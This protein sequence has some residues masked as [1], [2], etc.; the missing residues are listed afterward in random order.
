MKPS[1]LACHH[2]YPSR[3]IAQRVSLHGR[4]AGQSLGKEILARLLLS[5]TFILLPIAESWAQMRHYSTG[6]T[7]S[8]R[9]FCD[10]IPLEIENDQLYISVMMGDTPCRLNLDTGSGQGIVYEGTPMSQSEELG[11]V[12]SRDANGQQDT[13]R[14]VGLPPFRL[15]HSMISGYVASVLP[16]PKVPAPYDGIIGFDLFNKGLS[17]KIDTRQRILILTDQQQVFDHEE[18]FG[19]KYKLKWFVPYIYVSPFMRHTDEAL[20]D[21]GSRALYTM[22]KQSFDRHAYKS[23]HVAA[24]VEGRCE[25]QLS[26]GLLG[27]EAKSEVALLHL[28]RLKW[29]DLSFT[30]VRAVTTQG[31]SRIGTQLLRHGSV[32][33]LPH[34]RKMIFQPYTGGDSIHVGNKQAGT[35]FVPVN[36]RATV[37]LVWEGSE[38]YQGGMRQGDIVLR[39]NGQSIE[40]FEAFARYP[41][42]EGRQY[43]FVLRDARGFDKEVTLER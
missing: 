21:T 20:F 29:G 16:R 43:T 41:F 39:I 17:A 18:G 36:G 38:A 12:I 4:L 42:V 30:D 1:A 19:V 35:A 34:R 40:S 33:I 32:V 8:Q 2:P 37:G 6:F 25:G 11:S 14:V 7:L 23:R 22:S 24:Q 15:G 9:H 26:I 10:T 13:V 5:L 31:A 27:T 3:G 28:D